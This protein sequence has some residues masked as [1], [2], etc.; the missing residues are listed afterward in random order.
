MRVVSL[1]PSATES[2]VALGVRPVAVTRFC[3]L[4]GVRTIGGTKDPDVAA[5]GEIEPDLVVCCVEENRAEDADAITALGIEVHVLDIRTVADVKPQIAELAGAVG[6]CAASIRVPQALKVTRKAFVPIWR[7]PWMSLAADTYGASVLQHLGI[8]TAC[9]DAGDRYPEL[10][11]ADAIAR[12]PDLVIAPDE[13]YPFGP[14]QQEELE[15]VAPVRF[16]DGRDLFWWGTR[17][18]RALERLA[19]ALSS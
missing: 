18:P 3:H 13:P 14:R 17:T 12:R 8:G 4:A 11:L 19:T 16:V 15:A 5:I 7:K 1:V 2:L 9:A 6:A 10:E